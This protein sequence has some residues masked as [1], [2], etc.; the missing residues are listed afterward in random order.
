[1]RSS[2]RKTEAKIRSMCR[3]K[4]CDRNEDIDWEGGIEAWE[5]GVKVEW[6][7]FFFEIGEKIYSD[8]SALDTKHRGMARAAGAAV[9]RTATDGW[10]GFIVRIPKGLPRG[11][12]VPEQLAGSLA[13]SSAGPDRMGAS[14]TSS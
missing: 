4:D 12:A 2:I 13:L 3:T 14:V 7:D 1:M 8:G 5:D 10:R 9:Q 6:K 11:A